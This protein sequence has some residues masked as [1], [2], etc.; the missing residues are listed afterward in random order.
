MFEIMPVE[1]KEVVV[2]EKCVI[3]GITQIVAMCMLTVLALAAVVLDGSLG[4]M[5][6]VCIAAG[7]GG[8]VGYLFPS[9]LQKKEV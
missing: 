4:E 2:M 7:V 3:D 6:L 8:I 9:P 5:L 1:I